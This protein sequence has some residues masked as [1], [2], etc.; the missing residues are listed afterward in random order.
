MTGF[1]QAYQKAVDEKFRLGNIES[2]YNAPIA[3]LLASFGCHVIDVSGARKGAKDE[4]TDLLVW[5]DGE[6][7][8]ESEPFAAVEVKKLGDSRQPSRKQVKNAAAKY[9]YAIFTDNIRWEFWRGGE[10]KM[11]DGILLI[12]SD[13]KG[14]PVIT[15][16]SAEAFTILINSFLLQ[17]P[18]NIQSSNKLA[19]YMAKHAQTI[20]GHITRILKEDEN[21]QPVTS[22]RQYDLP[23][24]KELLGLYNRIKNDLRPYLDTR[25]F[26]DMYAQ[27]IVYG[28]FI[29]RY[30]D[31]AASTFD[32]YKAIGR[33]KEE[34][35][36]L[37]RF[38]AHITNTGANH[39]TLDA[40][41]DK[42]CSLYQL[43]D[44]STLLRCE[45]GGDTIVHFYEDFLAH[46]D[47]ALRKR[48]GVFYTPHQVVRYLVAMVDKLLVEDFN[49]A[50]GLSNNDTLQMTVDSEQYQI[51]RAKSRA[52]QEI[53]VPRVAILDPATGTGT[54]HAEIVKYIKETYFSGGRAPFYEKYIR[55]ENGLL[56]R[57]IGF[58]IMM[59]SYAVAHLNVRRTLEETLGHKTD[60]PFPLNI[61]LTNTLAKPNTTLE[62]NPYHYNLFD[63]SAAISDEAY[64]ADTWKARRPVK[65]IIGN[66]PYLAA[67]TTPYDIEA[68]KT[69]ADGATPFG[70]RKHGLNNDYV[71]FFSFAEKII[72]HNNEGVIA[73]VSD[74]GFLDN[75]TFRGMRG[76]LLR[77]FNKIYIVNLHGSANKQETAPDGGKD[78]NIFNIKQG[79][80]LFIGCKTTTGSGWAR[81]YYCDLW[82]KRKDKFTALT[83]RMLDFT[84]IQPDPKMAYL[85]PFGDEEKVRYEK[86]IRISELLPLHVTGVQTNN[87]VA[88][89]ANNKS[90][91]M[92]RI[93]IVKNAPND[94]AIRELWGKFS[95]GQ[96]AERIQN[97]VLSP[98][99]NIASICFRPFDER[100]TYY[101]GMSCGWMHRPRERKII[102]HLLDPAYT[103]AGKNFGLIFTRGDST[104]NTFSMVFVSDTLIDNRVTAAAQSGNYAYIAPLY[105]HNEATSTWLPN[106][107]PATH[108]QLTPHL[109]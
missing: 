55:E 62:R 96:T 51:S 68:Y 54:F 28:L 63:F 104:P 88:A 57:M 66:P 67:S 30:N 95:S 60:T 79:V 89:I 14:K 73:F 49:I 92:R 38:F 29:A 56:S 26:A 31:E 105:L 42:L 70:E 71:K 7:A 83:D 46:Y 36:L 21:G 32:R 1:I 97:D 94:D 4:N 69:E 43:C 53:S 34:S 15:P 27:T 85:I 108:A 18:A 100:W 72:N 10:E 106:F 35:A 59:T 12:E 6:D 11:Y 48:L 5:L 58:E 61:F 8:N 13:D 37:S 24:F 90:E 23:L 82:G 76:S 20:R 81:V 50:G 41:I 52:T 107:N 80:S 75:P 109:S 103:P 99:G 102:G 25:G 39:P 65:V 19:E 16:E 87:D 17:N 74:N 44:I 98:H 64:N 86:G 77:T 101:S 9:G 47:P 93:D 33:L 84:Q 78:E 45:R 22:Q 91:L 40:V 3:D 2:S